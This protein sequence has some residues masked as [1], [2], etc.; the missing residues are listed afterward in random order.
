MYLK[1]DPETLR[2]NAVQGVER[3][4]LRNTSDENV[5]YKVKTTAPEVYCVRPNVHTVKRGESLEVEFV[6]LGRG[7]DGSAHSDAIGIQRGDKFMI[8]SVPIGEQVIEKQEL[9]D[10]WDSVVEKYKQRAVSK[11]IPVYSV[12]SDSNTKKYIPTRKYVMMLCLMVL[13]IAYILRRVL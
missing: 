1:I 6:Y 9:E 11:K 8:I 5:I 4:T 3:V 12:H 7:S 2:F 13:I 10:R